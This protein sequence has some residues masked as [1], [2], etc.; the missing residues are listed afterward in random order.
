MNDKKLGNGPEQSGDGP[1]NDPLMGQL[2]EIYDDVAS[3]PLPQD[4][5]SL[6]EKL[7]AAERNR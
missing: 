6:L 7:D 3:Q 5:L 4:L 2:K 1:V